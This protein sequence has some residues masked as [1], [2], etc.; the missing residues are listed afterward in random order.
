MYK[1]LISPKVYSKETDLTY[2]KPKPEKNPK[3]TGAPGSGGGSTPIPPV[4]T[5]FLLTE[6]GFYLLQEDNFKI[7]L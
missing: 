1:T 6:E 4:N 7:L 5:F 3:A 2:R